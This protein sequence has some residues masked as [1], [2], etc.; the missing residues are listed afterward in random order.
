[1]RFNLKVF[2]LIRLYFSFYFFLFLQKEGAAKL[3][4]LLD[5]NRNYVTQTTRTKRVLQKFFFYN[6]IKYKNNYVRY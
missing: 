5:R 6:I 2:Q 4:F 3:N 1:M